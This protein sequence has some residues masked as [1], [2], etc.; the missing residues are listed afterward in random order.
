MQVPLVSGLANAIAFEF[1]PDGRIFIISRFGEVLIRKPGAAS[2]VS[3]GTLDVYHGFEDGL[4]G[5]AI[6]PGFSTN[7]HIYLYYSPRSP[8][9]NRL[10]RFTVVGD[11]IDMKSEVRMLDIPHQRQTCCH[12]AGDLEFDAQGNLYLSTG[13]NSVSHDY[14]SI[15]ESRRNASAEKSSSNTNDL[16]GKILRIHPEPDGSYTIPA[17]NLFPADELHRGEIFAMGFRNPYRFSVDAVSGWLYVG[18]V[19]AQA[20]VGDPEIGPRAYDEINQVRSPG[21][22]GWPYFVGPNL[23]Y[24]NP[25]LER[26]WDPAA[27][28]NN[29]V[30]N[31]GAVSLPPAR[32]SFIDMTHLSLMA[33]PVY[34]FDSGV[35]GR[36]KLPIEMNGH[37]LY[38]D[39]DSSRF[40]GAVL[41]ENGDR[42][43]IYPLAPGVIEAKGP[44]D[45]EIGPDHRLYVLDYGA[46]CCPFD[47][48]EGVLSRV[49]YVG[50][51]I[52]LSPPTLLSGVERLFQRVARSHPR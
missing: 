33:G 32:P 37:L 51:V 30:W 42:T 5:I 19:G 44:I 11:S 52:E 13:D 31:T 34:Y 12:V 45:M 23:A 3:A 8:S 2:V 14:R 20:N 9:V 15:S 35:A 21:N 48:N 49:D 18:D 43:E 7:R 38:F 40:G 41:D 29:S 25:A 10:S 36:N 46:G 27:P 16:R 22:Y 47:V 1:V 50:E 4:L 24:F 39:F 17:G 6:D 28:T 26:W